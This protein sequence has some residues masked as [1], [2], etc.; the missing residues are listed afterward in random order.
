MDAVA[1]EADDY[2]QKDSIDRIQHVLDIKQKERNL[3]ID[4]DSYHRV[5]LTDD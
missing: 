4:E 3:K 1:K 5:K 2:L